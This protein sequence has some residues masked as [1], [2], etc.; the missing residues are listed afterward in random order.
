MTVKTIK[1]K[2]KIH[3]NKHPSE[4]RYGGRPNYDI[5]NGLTKFLLMLSDEDSSKVL[6][7]TY[8]WDPEGTKEEFS[9]VQIGDKLG[10]AIQYSNGW[11]T[12]KMKVSEV[13][14]NTIRGKDEFTKEEIAY[15]MIESSV[16]RALGFFEILERDG[17]PFGLPEN[18]TQD[19]TLKYD[20]GK[21]EAEE[22]NEDIQETKKEEFPE[23][24]IDINLEEDT[25]DDDEINEKSQR[26]W[27]RCPDDIAGSDFYFSF[28]KSKDYFGPE[29]SVVIISKD[30][31][32]EE[33]VWGDSHYSSTFGK[34]LGLFDEMESVFSWENM[35]EEEVREKLI[36]SGAI[37]NNDLIKD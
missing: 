22:N 25:D 30:I 2:V 15:D 32:D 36:K 10:I 19:I 12:T 13:S 20:D 33:N 3:H 7:G 11:I 18:E 16:A 37:E 34:S 17:K 21:E 5:E 23:N 1:T 26:R 14:T 35:T 28:K 8:F 31:W 4:Y 27:R 29:N 24:G 6:N 9:N